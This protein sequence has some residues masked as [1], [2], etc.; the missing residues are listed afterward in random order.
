VLRCFILGD[1]EA[2]WRFGA[3]I[4]DRKKITVVRIVRKAGVLP[5]E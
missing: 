2:L 1:T 5:D 4:A 3:A